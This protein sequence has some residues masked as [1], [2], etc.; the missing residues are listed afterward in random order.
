M[1][2]VLSETRM[3]VP[4]ERMVTSALLRSFS[5]LKVMEASAS[6]LK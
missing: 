3:M 1:S 5:T 6:V 2:E 4:P